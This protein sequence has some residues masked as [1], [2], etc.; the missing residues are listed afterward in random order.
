MPPAQYFP[1]SEER[2]RQLQELVRL[3]Q[4]TNS[5]PAASLPDEVGFAH[6][7]MKNGRQIGRKFVARNATG[8]VLLAMPT[9]ATRAPRKRFPGEL[10]KDRDPAWKAAEALRKRQER[11]RKWTELADLFLSPCGQT[12]LWEW[13]K[14]KGRRS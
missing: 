5:I 12:F 8:M 3:R 7:R 6:V 13:R 4:P 10:A 11:L 9:V 1:G 14:S 2:I